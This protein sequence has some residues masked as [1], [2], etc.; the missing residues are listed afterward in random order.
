MYISACIAIIGWENGM[1]KS[2]P[3]IRDDDPYH[4]ENMITNAG[5]MD[6]MLR[7]MVMV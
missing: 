1:A 6:R 7:G 2:R 3:C 4:P 5:I